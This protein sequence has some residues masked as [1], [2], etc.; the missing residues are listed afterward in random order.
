V[1]LSSFWLRDTLRIWGQYL[2][3]VIA[4]IPATLL[5][6]VLIMLGVSE[7]R[8]TMISVLLALLCAY[9][10]WRLYPLLR[11]LVAPSGTT[12]TTSSGFQVNSTL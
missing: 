7:Q 3:I 2:T 11:Q 12:A 10:L 6:A 9:G 5:A 8:A 1:A 4:A